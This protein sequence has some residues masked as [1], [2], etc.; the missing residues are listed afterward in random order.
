MFGFIYVVSV[1]DTYSSMPGFYSRSCSHSPISSLSSF[2]SSRLRIRPSTCPTWTSAGSSSPLWC[3]PFVPQVLCQCGLLHLQDVWR[4]G[5]LV[6][7]QTSTLPEN[8]NK[9]HQKTGMKGFDAFILKRTG[10][11]SDKLMQH[12]TISAEERN[13]PNN[14]K[15]FKDGPTDKPLL[16]LVYLRWCENSFLY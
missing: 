1:D 10:S 14:V 8:R 3:S 12:W 13:F 16:K 7:V 11:D 4:F 2:C 15:W 9:P 6:S 5:V